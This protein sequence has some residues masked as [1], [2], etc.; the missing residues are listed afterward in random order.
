MPWLNWGQD[1][2]GGLD[3]TQ[4]DAKMAQ[5]QAAGMHVIRWWLF[6]GGAQHIQRNRSGVPTG[7]DASVY[8]DLDK[9][10]ALAA[11]HDIYLEM[12]L[13]ASP[14]D[15]PWFAASTST[16]QA[17]ANVLTPM[18]QRYASNSHLLAWEVVNE[19]DFNTGSATV[20]QSRDLIGKVTTA[21]HASGATLVDIDGTQNSTVGH[22]TGLGADFYS[23]HC[24]SSQCPLPSGLDK[25][26][27]VGEM[28]PDLWQAYYNSGFAGALCW[29]LSPEHT[30]D[31][32][33]CDMS[34]AKTFASGKA[35]I[36]PVAQQGVTPTPVPPTATAIPPTSTSVPTN[37]PAPTATPVPTSTSV[38]T[39]ACQAEVS[40]Y[41]GP[42]QFVPEPAA[43][44][45]LS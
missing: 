32:F 37:T 45:G 14:G 31:N 26:V 43:F 30:A 29:S 19:P 3:T 8:T 33:P 12:T 23:V 15:V 22:W 16:H 10:L 35:D 1:F 38:T 42:L 25:P 24:Y 44:C 13:F 20:T 7:I 11:K 39:P 27:V 17:L 2:G 28:D 40:I 9:A 4:T 6:E 21:I 36:G 18:F 41:G 34:G 5:A